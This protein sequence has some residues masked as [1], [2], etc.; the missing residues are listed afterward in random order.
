MPTIKQKKAL[1]RIVENRGNVSK[2]MIEAGYDETTAKNPKNLTE[3]K[4]WQ[5][6]ISK[7][8]DDEILLRWEDW[9]LNEQKEINQSLS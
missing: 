7:I 1:N 4:G 9:A 3:S 5:E 2:S 8:K 6:L